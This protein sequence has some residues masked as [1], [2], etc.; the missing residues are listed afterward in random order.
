VRPPRTADAAAATRQ[1]TIAKANAAW[2]PVAERPGDE[3]GEEHVAG[4][5]RLAVRGQRGE[6][7]RVDQVLHRVVAEE[8]GEQDRHRREVADGLRRGGRHAVD[9]EP[10]GE[11]VGERHGEPD[12]HQREEDADREHLGGVLEGWFIAPPAPRCSGGRL[13]ITA[14]R[15]GDANRPM[16]AP[17]RRRTAP[18][19]G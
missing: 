15:F 18:K 8:G 3:G 2:S 4:H 10:R 17:I 19:A 11:R 6:H 1:A 9:L 13:L 12:D 14:A 16:E 7:V 5:D